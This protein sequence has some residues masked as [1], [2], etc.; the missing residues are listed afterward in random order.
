MKRKIEHICPDIVD[1]II[2]TEYLH[3]AKNESVIVKC[4]TCKDIYHV[5]DMETT[6]NKYKC[7]ECNK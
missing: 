1:K 5:N 2:N 3:S 4:N 7:K 6:N